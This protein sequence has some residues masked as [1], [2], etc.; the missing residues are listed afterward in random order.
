MSYTTHSFKAYDGEDIFYYHWKQENPK[1]IV[2]IAHGLGEHAG[3]YIR[4]A[5]ILQKNGYEVYAND[6]RIHGH[7]VKTKEDLGVY[8][9]K[10]YFDDTIDDLHEFAQLILKEHPERKII[11]LSHS[12]GSMISREY[13]TKYND[14]LEALI[15][16]GTGSFI[17]GIGDLGVFVSNTVKLFKGRKPSS[18]LLK[19]LLFDEFNKKFKPNRTQVDWISSDEN[20]VD[21]FDKDPLRIE[22]FS[23]SMYVDLLKSSK[24]I[25]HPKTFKKTPNDLPIYMFSGDKD[26]VGEMG[27]G[28]KKVASEYKKYGSSNLTLKLYPGG[29]HEMLNEVNRNEVEKDLLNWLS[30]LQNAEA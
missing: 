5:E 12:M 28:V 8:D 24:K 4:I 10:N 2:Q 30:S 25:N 16:S 13:V 18:N 7:S 3:R 22:D 17:R 14:H 19:K 11:L 29:R 1:G 21:L 6:H 26:P 27:K 23:V 9:G 20:E 15:L